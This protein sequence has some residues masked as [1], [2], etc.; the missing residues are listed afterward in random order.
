MPF[1]TEPVD[2]SL[3]PAPLRQRR[4][5]TRARARVFIGSQAGD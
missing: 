3:Y 5:K 1:A 2:F 4:T